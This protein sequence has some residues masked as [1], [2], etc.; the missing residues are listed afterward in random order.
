[1]P[2]FSQRSKDKLKSCDFRLQAVFNKVI[3]IIDITI[4][5]GFRG[6]AAQEKAFAEGKSKAR[7]GES[8][9]NHH[10]SK[11]VD[12]APYPIDWNDIER[13]HR[14]AGI[15]QAVAFEEGVEIKWGG[16]FNNFFDGPHFELKN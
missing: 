7:W 1:M 9:H 3:Q 8:N 5:E 6:E 11:A 16:D 15:V 13:F 12:V 4:L 2:R 14:L 10:P